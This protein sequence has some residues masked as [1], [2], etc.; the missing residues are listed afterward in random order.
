MT[1]SFAGATLPDEGL[2]LSSSLSAGQSHLP[3][4]LCPRPRALQV[5]RGVGKGQARL[6]QPVGQCPV[7]PHSPS[8]P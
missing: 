3:P 5:K 8:S 7:L 4:G 2:G 1:L 6:S